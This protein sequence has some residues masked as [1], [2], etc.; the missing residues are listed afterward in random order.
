ME[1]GDY[2]YGANRSGKNGCCNRMDGRASPKRMIKCGID[3]KVTRARR[4]L[5]H[6]WKGNKGE[7]VVM[8][9]VRM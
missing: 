1:C 3:K 4:K 8:K 7:M 5:D 9:Q 2:D 6:L